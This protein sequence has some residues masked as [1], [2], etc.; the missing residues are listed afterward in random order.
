MLTAKV[1][2]S[3]LLADSHTNYSVTT[4]TPMN[5][6]FATIAA[7]VVAFTAP[8]S[9]QH[10]HP[11]LNAVEATGTEVVYNTPYC[12]E[13]PNSLG[14]YAV[15]RNSGG[16]YLVDQLGICTNN[17]DDASMMSMVIRHEA[18]H[19]IQECNGGP[20]LGLD[21][22]LQRMPESQIENIVMA[23]PE[24]HIHHELEAWYT[25]KHL[26]DAQVV[27]FIGKFCS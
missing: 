23:Y 3:P 18:I 22:Y 11:V 17:M 16:K 7:S 2:V 9:A 8:V 15:L 10:R 21:Y 14:Y 5:K 24:D 12:A 13:N 1:T 19:V 4:S 27:K 26:S 25:S 20:L 6:F